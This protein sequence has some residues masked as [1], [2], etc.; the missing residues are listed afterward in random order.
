MAEAFLGVALEK[1]CNLVESEFATSFGIK[2]KIEQLSDTLELIKA[3]L[4]D[5]EEK[6]WADGRIKV[7][8]LKLKGAVHVLDD[9]LEDCLTESLHFGSSSSFEPTNIMH[10]CDVEA[11]LD[12]MIRRLHQLAEA[13]NEFALRK[14]V[15]ERPTEV[16]EWRQTSSIITPPQVYGR[17]EDKKKVVEFLLSPE[18]DSDSLSVYPIVG[19]GG[20]G[21][22]TLAQLVYN[23][24]DVRNHF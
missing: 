18:R 9:I 5:A 22:T 1:L 14:G 19:L 8:L 2:Q 4:D 23:D 17:D 24:Q 20:L 15:R 7:W 10:R 13:K 16:A 3:V 12:E 21:K 11:K 6:Q